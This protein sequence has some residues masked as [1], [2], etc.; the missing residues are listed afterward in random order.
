[1]TGTEGREADHRSLTEDD[2]VTS[3][4]KSGDVINNCLWVDNRHKSGVICAYSK[5]GEED[6]ICT[7]IVKWVERE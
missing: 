6:K 3:L 2:H 1:M 4:S 7:L 5:V